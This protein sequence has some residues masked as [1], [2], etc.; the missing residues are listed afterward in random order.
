MKYTSI[1][2]AG[3]VATG[4]STTA[5]AL[6]EKLNLKYHSPGDFFRQYMLE[7]DI[8]LYD[9][10]RFPDDLDEKLDAEQTKLAKEG[11]YVIDTHYC[12]YFTRNMPNVLKVRLTCDYKTRIERAL[13]RHHTHIETEE[14]IIKR[15]IEMDKKFRKLYSDEDYLNSKFFD[16]VIDT[17][18]NPLDSVVKQIE[19]KF[20]G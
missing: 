14:D 20:K 19:E 11:G 7:N 15:E 2:I 13:S 6:A 9:K 10:E 5:K 18:N 4:T 1:V 17:T 3:N 8:P 16:L 12:G